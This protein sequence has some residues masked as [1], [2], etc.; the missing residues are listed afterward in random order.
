VTHLVIFCVGTITS[1]RSQG[2][3]WSRRYRHADDRRFA[4]DV[5]TASPARH[6]FRTSQFW[7]GP[8]LAYQV[9]I[10][11]RLFNESLFGSALSAGG[12]SP[13]C[14]RACLD[15][16]FLLFTKGASADI[17]FAMAPAVA[18][19]AKRVAETPVTTQGRGKLVH[20]EARD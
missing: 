3:C 15:G 5:F 6:G 8:D 18:L 7:L 19:I 17:G 2:W 11:D 20:R 10:V 4:P 14:A 16:P 13:I 9:G 12:G 1:G